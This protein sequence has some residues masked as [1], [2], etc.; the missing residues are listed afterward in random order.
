[1]SPAWVAST[2]SP[3]AA[4]SAGAAVSPGAAESPGASV[5]PLI[6]SAGVLPSDVSSSSPPHAV[7]TRLNAAMD[8]SAIRVFFIVLGLPLVGVLW[9]PV[10]RQFAWHR[11]SA[12]SVRRYSRA[13][14]PPCTRTRR[15]RRSA[16]ESHILVEILYVDRN[17]YGGPSIVPRD[18]PASSSRSDRK[19]VV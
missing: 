1:M 7:A 16:A 5:P 11:S 2:V 9:L 14:L 18:T 17:A 8:A 10:P 15:W 13:T 3:G 19:S 6:E 12:A 4:V